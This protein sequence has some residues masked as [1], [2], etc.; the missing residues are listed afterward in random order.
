MTGTVAWDPL[1]GL[2]AGAKTSSWAKAT[3]MYAAA[4]SNA[5]EIFFMAMMNLSE[6]FIGF[7]K[8]VRD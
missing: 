4:K 7:E 5:Q 3:L 2:G 1:A 6:N 8:N